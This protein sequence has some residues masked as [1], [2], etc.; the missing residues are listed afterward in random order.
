MAI[1]KGSKVAV[2]ACGPV[3]KFIGVVTK[4]IVPG[5]GPKQFEVLNTSNGETW[6]RDATELKPITRKVTS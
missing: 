5:R 1:R 3:K 4:V 2:A 6:H